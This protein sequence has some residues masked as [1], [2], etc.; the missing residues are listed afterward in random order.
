MR[1]YRAERQEGRS[2]SIAF[3]AAALDQ[4]LLLTTSLAVEVLVWSVLGLWAV[5]ATVYRL[6]RNLR[7]EVARLTRQPY[8][9]VQDSE[10]AS[11]VNIQVS[12]QFLRRPPV[13]FVLRITA[14]ADNRIPA[15]VLA[16]G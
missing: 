3:R 9:I 6:H 7:Q 15:Q 16:G 5:S 11:L 13:S 2:R 8:S 12:I 4:C 10:W 14:P 1:R